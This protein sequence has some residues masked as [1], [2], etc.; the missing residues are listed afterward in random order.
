VASGLRDHRCFSESGI[1]PDARVQRGSGRWLRPASAPHSDHLPPNASLLT[2]VSTR[3]VRAAV[4]A[5]RADTSLRSTPRSRT[6]QRSDRCEL[7]SVY[8]VARRGGGSL[9]NRLRQLRAL[10]RAA[11]SPL[12]SPRRS[13]PRS[14]TGRPHRPRRARAR[15]HRSAALT[16]SCH[17]QRL[18]WIGIGQVLA[19][20]GDRL[21]RRSCDD[22]P[23]PVRSR[24]SLVVPLPIG[25]L[26]L[27]FVAAAVAPFARLPRFC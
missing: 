14:A 22:A 6:T 7:T 1:A 21:P 10:W 26:V 16:G 4:R 24:S 25:V 18:P 3:I 17:V 19:T 15:P 13:C 23:H 2:E 8:R 12:S 9:R 27:T 11:S 5:E 20:L